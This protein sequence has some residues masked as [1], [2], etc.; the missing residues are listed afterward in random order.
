MDTN[1][2]GLVATIWAMFVVIQ[3]TL[4]LERVWRHRGRGGSRKEVLFP[5]RFKFFDF[6]NKQQRWG[7]VMWVV[8]AATPRIFLAF[9][10][11]IYQVNGFLSSSVDRSPS[12]HIWVSPASCTWQWRESK[13]SHC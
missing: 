2:D 10:L 1:L 8:E 3:I 12:P 6:C 4:E 11:S 9:D 7:L 13:Q 5:T